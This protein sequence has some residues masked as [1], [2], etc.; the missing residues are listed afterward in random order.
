MISFL[1]IVIVTVAAMTATQ[2]AADDLPAP[3]GE[4]LLTVSGAIARTN[5]DGVARFDLE[6]LQALEPRSFTT[7]TIWTEGAQEFTGVGLDVLL[8]YLGSTGSMLVTTAVND[9]SVEIPVSDATGE[10]PIVAYMRNG[11]P[12]PLR[13]KGPLWVVYPYDD[14]A[15]YRSELIYARSIWQMNRIEVAE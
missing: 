14:K 12:M 11:A 15:E 4:V 10:G 8:T 1:R 9:Y 5:G 13:Q 3:K 6:M 7:E 2:V